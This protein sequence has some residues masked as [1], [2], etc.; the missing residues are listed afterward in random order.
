MA[1]RGRPT[2][3]TDDLPEKLRSYANQ[4]LSKR[5]VPWLEEFCQRNDV[6]DRRLREWCKNYEELSDARDYMM[7]IQKMILKQIAITRG[8]NVSGAIFLLKANHGL[9]ETEKIQHTSPQE[10]PLNIIFTDVA[11]WR[12][13]K[14]NVS[15]RGTN[16]DK[17]TPVQESAVGYN[18]SEHLKNPLTASQ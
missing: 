12:R 9:I 10:E 6:S 14:E 16:N 1:K 8:G 11:T 2:D 18:W 4:C 3:Y 5:Q 17:V 15:K 13:H 7:M